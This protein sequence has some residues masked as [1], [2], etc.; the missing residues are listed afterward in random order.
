MTHPSNSTHV[1]AEKLD[2]KALILQMQRNPKAFEELLDRLR[3][4][5]GDPGLE[6]VGDKVIFREVQGELRRR[7][8]EMTVDRSH[9][10]PNR[11]DSTRKSRY[12]ILRIDPNNREAILEEIPESAVRAPDELL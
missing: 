9:P 4:M 10:L 8:A 1:R 3:V 11:T 7:T 12:K 2:T 5:T 6:I